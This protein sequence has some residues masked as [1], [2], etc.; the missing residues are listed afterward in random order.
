MRERGKEKRKKKKEKKEKKKKKE[1]GKKGKRK[2]SETQLTPNLRRALMRRKPGVANV[3]FGLLFSTSELN[4]A[5]P[6]T[7]ASRMGKAAALSVTFGG[8]TGKGLR[9]QHSDRKQK[10][11]C[12]PALGDLEPVRRR[13]Q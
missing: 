9:K 1:K 6:E 4:D 3:M 12:R 8:L 7:M 13:Q 2:K 5:M 10:T 11:V